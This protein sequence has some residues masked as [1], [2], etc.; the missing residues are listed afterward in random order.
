MILYQLITLF[1]KKWSKLDKKEIK[2]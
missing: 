1:E 2:K